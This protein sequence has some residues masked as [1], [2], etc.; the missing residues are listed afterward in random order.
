MRK[1]KN[2]ILLGFALL[3]VQISCNKDTKNDICENPDYL[4][5]IG[6]LGKWKLDSR[7]ING[8]SSLGVECC[9]YLQ[10]SIDGNPSDWNGVFKA[11]GAGYEL[12][13]VFEMDTSNETIEFSYNENQK[14][15]D[16]QLVDLSIAFSYT[17][18]GDSIVEQ[19]HKN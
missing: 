19:W 14:I 11:Y 9:D 8:I 15:Y 5:P 4:E 3:M 6:I 10:F 17:E 16:Y 1:L 12:N 2:M 18:N 7:E 13:G